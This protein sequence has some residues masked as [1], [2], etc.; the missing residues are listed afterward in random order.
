MTGNRGVVPLHWVA[1]LFRRSTTW[2]LPGSQ[3]RDDVLRIV[4]KTIGEMNFEIKNL[5]TLVV[6]QA[7]AAEDQEARLKKKNSESREYGFSTL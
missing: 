5:K 1:S 7:A 4:Q 3:L 2:S 6:A